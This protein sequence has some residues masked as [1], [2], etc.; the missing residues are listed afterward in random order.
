LERGAQGWQVQVAVD[1]AELLGGR[2]H[3][4][5]HQRSAIV[6]S[7]QRLTL[8]A[9]SRQIEIIDSMVFVERSVRARVGG[10]PNR[11]TVR[12]SASPSRRL[13]AAPGWVLSSSRASVD[14]WASASKAEAAR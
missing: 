3:P 6:P 12:V 4:A 7:C 11:S 8:P 5:A 2:N 9:W 14:S 10:T 13:A 1:A